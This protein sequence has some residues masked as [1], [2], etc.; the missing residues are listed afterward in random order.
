MKTHCTYCGPSALRLAAEYGIR[1]SQ[2]VPGRKV[3]GAIM[4]RC[5]CCGRIWESKAKWTKKA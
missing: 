3:K 5:L 4:A 2:V 1:P